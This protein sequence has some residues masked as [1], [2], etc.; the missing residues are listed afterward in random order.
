MKLKI[1]KGKQWTCILVKL[2]FILTLALSFNSCKQDEIV[3][4][5]SEKTTSPKASVSDAWQLFVRLNE[6][7][8]GNGEVVANF[9]LL[10]PSGASTLNLMLKIEVSGQSS[11][12]VGTGSYTFRVPPPS[13]PI[14]TT[15]TML[16]ASLYRNGVL[17]ASNASS[18]VLNWSHGV[19]Q[20]QKEITFSIPKITVDVLGRKTLE[21]QHIFNGTENVTM[22]VYYISPDYYTPEGNIKTD[23]A[24][25]IGRYPLSPASNTSFGYHQLYLTDVLMGIYGVNSDHIKVFFTSKDYSLFH[26]TSQVPGLNKCNIIDVCMNSGATTLDPD[27]PGLNESY[28]DINSAYI[29]T[30]SNFLNRIL[31]AQIEYFF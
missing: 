16:K 12:L 14:G 7:S 9:D 1:F 25:F 19:A 29:T 13:N 6:T 2:L 5:S 3:F 28:L 30:R 15:T 27:A 31:D 8:A 11:D 22:Y 4:D 17:L 18:I 24:M 21:I 20:I 10:P 26:L 23:K